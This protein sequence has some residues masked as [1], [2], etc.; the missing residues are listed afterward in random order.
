MQF[1]DGKWHFE[2]H[3][4]AQMK[5][6]GIY[7]AKVIRQEEANVLIEGYDHSGVLWQGWWKDGMALVDVDWDL[8]P[9]ATRKST[10]IRLSQAAQNKLSELTKLYGNQ[11]T[12]IEVAVDRLYQQEIAPST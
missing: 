9:N 5:E 3:E 1:Q 4:R 11:T 8:S 12:A 10:S 2:P 6:A 7:R